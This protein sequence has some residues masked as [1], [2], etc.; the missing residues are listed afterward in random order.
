[1]TIRNRKPNEKVLRKTTS[2]ANVLYASQKI[3]K[4]APLQSQQQ[5]QPPKNK[6]VEENISKLVISQS[7]P[8]NSS[9]QTNKNPTKST[10]PTS[11]DSKPI[12]NS[13]TSHSKAKTSQLFNIN[14]ANTNPSQN[15]L[16]PKPTLKYQ[17][18]SVT[19][20]QNPSLFHPSKIN[21]SSTPIKTLI[22]GE[23]DSSK[24][25]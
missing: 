3:I 19:N 11:K 15:I 10:Q 9:N 2:S 5:L 25:D 20:S 22:N 24:I 17:Q 18:I 16:P 4:S 7:A 8:I 6:N 23:K 1:M 21:M 14:T 12:I 13:N